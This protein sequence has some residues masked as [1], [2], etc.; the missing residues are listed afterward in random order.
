MREA[1]TNTWWSRTLCP[2][3]VALGLLGISA[4]SAQ[5]SSCNHRSHQVSGSTSTSFT[6]LTEAG[7]VPEA[8]S[9]ALPL[10]QD[11]KAPRPCSGPSCSGGSNSS[12]PPIPTAIFVIDFDQWAHFDSALPTPQLGSDSLLMSDSAEYPS[13]ATDPLLQPPRI[14]LA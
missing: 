10:R 3:L 11:S 7:A 12:L 13:P 8:S 6:W 5:A 2:V 4:S 9:A 1:R 14:T